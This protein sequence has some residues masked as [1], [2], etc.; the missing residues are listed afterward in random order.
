MEDQNIIVIKRPVIEM[1]KSVIKSLKQ[2][3]Y[4]EIVEPNYIYRINTITANDPLLP[5]LWGMQNTGQQDSAGRSGTPGVD[6]GA[7]EAWNIQTGSKEVIVAVIDTGV[8]YNTTDLIQN[9]WTNEAEKNGKEGV[10]DDGNGFVDDIYGYNFFAGNGDPMDDHGHGT[11]CSGTIGAKGNDGQGIV[12]VAW[13]VRIMALKFLGQDGSGS[14]EAAIRAIDY[15]TKNGAKIMSNSWGGGAY[16]ETLK[17]AI[18]RA[19]KAGAIFIAAA[20]NES[21]NND[22]SPAYPASYNVPNVLSVAA[23]D[24]GGELASFSNFGKATVHVAA[25]GVNIYST[26]KNGYES[27][28]GTSMATP[29]VSGI[30]VLLYSEFPEMTNI[31]VRNRI[32]ETVK[33]TPGLRRKAS[34]RGVANAYLALM[35]IKT[36]EDVNDPE[37]WAFKSVDVSTPHPYKEKSNETYEVKVDG[38]KEV[39]IYFEKFKTEAKYDTVKLIDSTG[40]EV[41]VYSGENDDTISAV[42]SG[43]SVKIIFKSDATDNSYGFDISKIYYR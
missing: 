19:N 28:S 6:I 11:H 27:W 43:D 10:D 39:A 1:Q 34:S 31:E 37:K 16:S 32:I 23:I 17:Q 26:T 21:N 24:N 18:Q 4:V 22:S 9:I 15:A 36:P 7:T 42:I 12:G 13:N 35:N 20:G 25:P 30:A 33:L 3:S 2:N 38:A 41:D 5:K 14:L 40:K 8:N 29:H